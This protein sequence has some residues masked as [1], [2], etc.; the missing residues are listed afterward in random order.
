MNKSILD[1]GW[2]SQ[3]G[4]LLNFDLFVYFCKKKDAIAE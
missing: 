1:L 3:E 2:I 4:I